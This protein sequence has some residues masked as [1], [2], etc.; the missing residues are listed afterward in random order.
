MI[1]RNLLRVAVAAALSLVPVLASAQAFPSRPIRI[2]VPYAAGGQPDIVARVVSKQMSVALGQPVT[3]DNVTGG[4]GVTAITQL[5]GQRPDGYTLIALDAGHW[6]IYPAG[7]GPSTPYDPV[8]SFTPVSLVTT[9]SLFLAVHESVPAKNMAE[10]LSLVKQQPGKLNYGSSGIGSLHHLTIEALKQSMGLDIMH[11]PYRGTGQSVPA[12]VG[13]QVQLVVA[14]LS[15]LS[16][17]EKAGKVRILAANTAARSALAPDVPAISETAPGL[18][19]PGQ[20]GFLAPAGLPKDIADKL[21]AAVDE[22]MKSPDVLA[23]LKATGVEPAP[24]RTAD[25]LARRIQ[26]DR[27]RYGTLIKST[28]IQL[29]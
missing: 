8:K 11:V 17:F 29:E 3:V 24:S 2:I 1:F 23:G 5:I 10:L 9:S 15:V 28:G 21:L 22:A 20:V 27:T 19:F 12:L 26:E 16:Q 25:T 4:S 14:S 13:G 7:R 18:D 6:A